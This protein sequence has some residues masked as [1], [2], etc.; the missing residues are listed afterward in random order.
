MPTGGL[1]DYLGVEILAK[2]RA[3]SSYENL[4]AWVACGSE[5]TMS[6]QFGQILWTPDMEDHEATCATVAGYVNPQ[7]RRAPIPPVFRLRFNHQLSGVSTFL[8]SASLHLL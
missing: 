3:A 1:P 5:G 4:Q 6:E 8:Y 7:R 2:D